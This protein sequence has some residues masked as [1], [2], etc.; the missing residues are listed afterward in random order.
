MTRQSVS[1][2]GA[3]F[4][5]CREALVLA[6]YADGV[7]ESSGRVRYSIGFGSQT[8]EVLP[9]QTIT[10][11]EA[12][13]R[14]RADIAAREEAVNRALSLPVSQGAF[15]ALFSL[16]YQAGSAALRD[17]AN[18][19]NQNAEPIAALAFARW[20]FGQSR[21][22]TPGHAKRRIAEMAMAMGNYGDLSKLAFYPGN[23]RQTAREL[24]DFPELPS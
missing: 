6:A 11:P 10:V 9:D 2:L 23:P 7:E 18:S 19:F 17:V 1:V 3:K 13:D 16:Y 21:I 22:P 8:P 12:F 4:L 5:A 20:P 24:I 15:D 14:L